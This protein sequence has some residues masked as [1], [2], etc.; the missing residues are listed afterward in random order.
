[1]DWSIFLVLKCIDS[2]AECRVAVRRRSGRLTHKMTARVNNAATLGALSGPGESSALL[3]FGRR[4]HG[5]HACQACR[6]RDRAGRER[7]ACVDGGGFRL[8]L[9]EARIWG[10]EG[11]LVEWI[12]HSN[13]ISF[14]RPRKN[15]TRIV[16]FFPPF[17]SPKFTTFTEQEIYPSR[18]PSLSVACLHSQKDSKRIKWI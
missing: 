15:N 7:Q 3:K 5:G 18:V 14:L 4:R 8:P 6:A 16:V 10:T 11:Q 13:S 1:M 2:G 12:Q 17:L 9:W